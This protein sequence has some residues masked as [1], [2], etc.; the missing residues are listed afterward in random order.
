MILLG[1]D[2][3]TTGC[4]VAAYDSQMHLLGIGYEEYPLMVTEDFIELDADRVFSAVLRCIQ[5]AS[6]NLD[7]SEIGAISVS[8][9]IDTFTP[10]GSDGHPLMGSIVSFDKRASAQARQIR[11]QIGEEA[12]FSITGV[13]LHEMFPGCKF[14]WLAQHRPEIASRTWKYLQYEDYLLFRL[15]APP[16][17]SYS[18]VKNTLVFDMHKKAFSP[19]LMDMCKV[20]QDQLPEPVPSGQV[21]GRLAPHLAR[22]LDLNENV[23]LV[24]G[25]FDQ[26]CCALALGVTEKGQVLDTLGTNEIL[27]YPLAGEDFSSLL[28]MQMNVSFHVVPGRFGSY[29]QVINA[30]GGFRWC[31]DTLFA[32]E[33]EEL[34]DV[35]DYITKPLS[36]TP[37]SVLF[38][39]FLSGVGTPD[40]KRSMKAA[41]YGI[42]ID[43]DR[44]AI[45][46]GILEGICCEMQYNLDAIAPL[47]GPIQ[48]RITVVGGGAKSPYWMQLKADL[49]GLT[50]DAFPNVEAG[51][52]GAAILAAM[53]AGVFKGW[54][55]GSRLFRAG[56]NSRTYKP[57]ESVHILYKKRMEEYLSFRKLIV[58]AF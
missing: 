42:G 13:P 36:R 40:M 48:D 57:E 52:A 43:S 1:I 55:E 53:G 26:A 25:G 28:P 3:G 2:A 23:L 8:S 21:C 15:G 37:G 56:L 12:L 34:T 16:V 27:Y 33:K 5:T 7:R 22:A 20:R 45:S 11:E 10:I 35:Y 24:S 31:R 47:T 14:L 29:A 38:L 44:F 50:V 32:K 39:P 54:T 17:S 4:K 6:Q 46:Q 30:G 49:L 41:F 58:S 51:T 9:M 18:S 19:L